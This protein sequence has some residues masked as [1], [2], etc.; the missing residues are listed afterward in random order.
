MLTF[1][2]SAACHVAV[3]LLICSMVEL[4]ADNGANVNLQNDAGKT[5]LVSRHS[6]G[7]H[8]KLRTVFKKN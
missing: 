6:Y 8:Y 3:M 7:L 2:A 5:A 1:S 4:L